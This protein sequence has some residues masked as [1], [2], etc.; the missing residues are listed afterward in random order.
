M[1]FKSVGVFDRNQ[2]TNVEGIPIEARQLPSASST[3]LVTEVAEGHADLAA[4]WDGTKV[5]F[6]NAVMGTAGTRLTRK[7]GSCRL[8]PT[9]CPTIC[10]SRR[11]SPRGFEAPST[12]AIVSDSTAGRRA[13]GTHPNDDFLAWHVWDNTEVGERHGRGA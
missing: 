4:V 7:S 2:T 9:S 1:Y 12:N 5:K 11:G 13:L 6:M 3:T 10:S 8:S